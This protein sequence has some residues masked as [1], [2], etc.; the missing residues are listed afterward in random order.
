MSTALDRQR[1]HAQV[2]AEEEA[3][4]RLLRSHRGR[5]TSPSPSKTPA[6]D[7]R[8]APEP[9]ERG[10]SERFVQRLLVDIPRWHLGERRAARELAEQEA[11]R[12][13][14]QRL[15]AHDQAVR[16]HQ[17]DVARCKQE[18]ESEQRLL[19][20]A[21]RWLLDGDRAHARRAAQSAL[22]GFPADTELL[23]LDDRRAG[24]ALLLPDLDEVIPERMTDVT[25][26]GKPTTRKRP[27]G[28]RNDLYA[29]VICA[30]SLGV[31]TALLT[32]TPT[33]T[34]VEVLAL[35]EDRAPVAYC[36]VA[37]A[38]TARAI[39]AIEAFYDCDGI[40]EQGGRVRTI[41]TLDARA[42]PQVQKLLGALDTRAR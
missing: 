3:L 17:A 24:V 16:D 38:D 19:D 15:Q 2:R 4:E 39:D 23:L 27:Q 18:R 40:L 7:S 31:A 35:D 33:T 21:H 37:S 28:E 14:Q 30:L 6:R 1:Q 12:H 5:Q 41:Q 34:R 29:E 22:A 36:S 8:S 26:G 13:H 25:P 9:P 10:T 32:A 42:E 20:L 11:D